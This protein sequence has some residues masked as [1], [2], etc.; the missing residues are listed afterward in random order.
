MRRLTLFVVAFALTL[1]YVDAD[2][3]K[4]KKSCK[5]R[6]KPVKKGQKP[7]L[8]VETKPPGA[9]VLEDG[10]AIGTAPLRL[11]HPPSDKPVQ[12]AVKKADY[13]TERKT[14]KK[15]RA[16]RLTYLYFN[17]TKGKG[18]KKGK[19]GPPMNPFD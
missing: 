3:G 16:D 11:I 5:P 9:T 18:K 14:V 10:C 1:P 4:A 15:I 8:V 19:K 17:L 6:T 12:F 2:A 13:R 7:N